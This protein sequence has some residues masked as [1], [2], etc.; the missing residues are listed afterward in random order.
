[1][2]MP[3]DEVIS[4]AVSFYPTAGL[5]REQRYSGETIDPKNRHW[6]KERVITI[7]HTP[8]Q[9]VRSHFQM[10]ACNSQLVAENCTGRSRPGQTETQ[11]A[12]SLQYFHMTM[13]N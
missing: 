6:T 3:S 4:P 5:L 13:L 9:T 2:R 11:L 12:T 10:Y 1:M 7:A 8:N